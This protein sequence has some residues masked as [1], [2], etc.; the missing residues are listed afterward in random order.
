MLVMA[1]HLVTL[2]HLCV[3]VHI[4]ITEWIPAIYIL[5]S[6]G[7]V[8]A[9]YLLYSPFVGHILMLICSCL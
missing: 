3:Y 7:N 8:A 1:L 6:Q 4:S 9:L 5:H 2:M